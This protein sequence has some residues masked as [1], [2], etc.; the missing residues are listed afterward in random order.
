MREAD[1]HDVLFDVATEH[2]IARLICDDVAAGDVLAQFGGRHI[3]DADG[4]DLPRALQ[5]HQARH[6]LRDG[7]LVRFDRRPVRL[8]QI[9]AIGGQPPQAVLNSSSSDPRRQKS[10]IR[11][12]VHSSWS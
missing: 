5:V 10:T 12:V 9:D 2:T 8:I 6:G 4:T 11:L 1:G 7:G 3:R